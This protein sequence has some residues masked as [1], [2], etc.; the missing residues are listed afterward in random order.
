[1][2]WYFD[3]C[4]VGSAHGLDGGATEWSWEFIRAGEGYDEYEPCVHWAHACWKT[5]AKEKE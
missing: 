3:A 2:L 5:S 4:A 1:M